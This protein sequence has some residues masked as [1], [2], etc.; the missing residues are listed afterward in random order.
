MEREWSHN[1][2][3]SVQCACKSVSHSVSSHRDRCKRE[4]DVMQWILN[5][6]EDM[7]RA[8]RERMECCIVPP[9]GVVAAGSSP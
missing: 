9:A 3:Q 8:R 5:W 2:C 1:G 6:N 4:M 7:E